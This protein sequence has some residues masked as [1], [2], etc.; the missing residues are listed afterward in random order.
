[1]ER[2]II[3]VDA[4]TSNIKAAAFSVDGE[5]LTCSTVANPVEHPQPG[6]AEQDMTAIWERAATVLQDVS[7]TVRTESEILGVGVTG[8]GDGCWLVDDAGAPVRNAILWSDGRAADIVEEWV[9]DGRAALISE[10][11]KSDI[12]PGVTL[13]ILEWL[14]ENEPETLEAASTVFYC[15][16]WLKFK[17]TGV[18]TTDYS[19]ATIPFLDVERLEYADTVFDVVDRDGLDELLPALTG[20]AEVIGHV[21]ETAAGATGVPEGTPVISGVLDI[22]ANAI[23]SGAINHGESSAIVGTTSLNQTALSRPP[24]DPDGNGFTLAVDEGVYLRSMASMAGTPNIDWIYDEVVGNRDFA[25]METALRAVPPGADGLLYHPYLST[26]G[27][28]SPFLKTSARAGFVGLSPDHTR[29]HMVRAVYEGVSLAMR[30]VFEHID[31]ETDR[32]TMSGGGS[33]SEFWCQLFADCLDASVVLPDGDEL[34]AKG[35]ALLT[36]VAVGEYDSLDAAIERAVTYTDR[37][38]PD[39]ETVAVYDEWYEFY[40]SSYE[41]LFDV[42]DERVEAVERIRERQSAAATR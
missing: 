3:G 5:Q 22:P 4:G 16:D 26:S 24:T 2:V 32:V 14:D 31:T 28:R 8:Q 41:Q 27:E 6:W 12:F 30:D 17:L 18:R 34:G 19:D 38:T 35:V 36:G 29:D 40:R 10:L 11:T 7:E 1:M 33:R 42:W 39:P 37:F 9:E 15:K 13:P 23:G 21:T 20:P 25:G